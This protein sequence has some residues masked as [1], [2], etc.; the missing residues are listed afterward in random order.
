ML[1]RAAVCAVVVATL[2]A[3][4]SAPQGRVVAPVGVG[5]STGIVVVDPFQRAGARPIDYT[6]PR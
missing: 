3:M 6:P 5:R 2:L 1:I 4:P